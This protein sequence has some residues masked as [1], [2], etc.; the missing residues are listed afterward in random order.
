MCRTLAPLSALILLVL[1]PLTLPPGCATTPPPA[2]QHVLQRFEFR[3]VAMGVGASI[4][5]FAPDEAVATAGAKAA[6]ERIEQI[7]SV[8]SDY[9]VNSEVS[10]LPARLEHSRTVEIHPDLAHAATLAKSLRA[11]TGGAFDER[12]G[13]LTRLWRSARRDGIPP[14]PQAARAAWSRSRVDYTIG[15]PSNPTPT[16][17]ASGPIWLDFG[18]IAKGLACDE[19]ARVLRSHGIVRF[20]IDLGGDLLLGD[21]PPDA[22]GWRVSI[23]ALD[24]SPLMV[25]LANVAVATSGARYQSLIVDGV[26]HSHI[27]DPRTGEP[28]TMARGVT[29]LARDGATADALASALSVLGES[30][31]ELMRREFPDAQWR[32]LERMPGGT[33]RE[34]LASNFPR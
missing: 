9:R 1:V 26:E 32:I 13:E 4:V 16:L 34:T 28:I 6:Q 14:D 10:T 17:T 21:P 7:E 3:W 29:V 27:I 8:L 19:A 12:L 2:E 18:G 20:L 11:T 24:D 15:G 5:M 23:E 30:G 25:E 33:V 22:P 31:S